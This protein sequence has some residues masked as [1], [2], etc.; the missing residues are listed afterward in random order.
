MQMHHPEPD[1]V[2]L[3]VEL[4]GSSEAEARSTL[5]HVGYPEDANSFRTVVAGNCSSNEAVPET[6]SD[7]ATGPGHA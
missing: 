4:T 7:S 2:R 3:Y 5:M 6:I 1:M